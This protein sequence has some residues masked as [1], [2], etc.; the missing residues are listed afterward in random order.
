MRAGRASASLLG[1][2]LALAGCASLLPSSQA[3]VSSPWRSF[4]DARDAIERIEPART[5]VRQLS[6]AGI[7]PYSSRNVQL[8]SYSDILLRFPLHSSQAETVD[9]GL[10]ECLEAGKECT[11]YSI[12]VRE[13]KSSRVGPFWLDAFGFKRVVE[14]TGWQFNALIL[15]VDERVVYTLYGGQPNLREHGVSRQPLGPMQ[16][17]GDVIPNPIPTLTK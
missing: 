8:L 6:Q 12:N 15:L 13:V 7:D 14:T 4:E 11:G 1:A 2:A 17:L 16:N 3:E 9:P 10:R 5:T